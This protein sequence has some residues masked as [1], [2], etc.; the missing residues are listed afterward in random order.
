M[1]NAKQKTKNFTST[2]LTSDMILTITTRNKRTIKQSVVV[3]FPLIIRCHQD[4]SIILAFS[5]VGRRWRGF[6][7]FVMHFFFSA[8]EFI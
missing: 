5:F 8:Q 7:V 2:S 3:A 6:L 4:R 1:N